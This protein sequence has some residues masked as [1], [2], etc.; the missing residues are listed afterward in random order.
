MR[1]D[2]VDMIFALTSYAMF[3]MLMPGRSTSEL[4]DLVRAACH[5]A[6]DAVAVAAD[7]KIRTS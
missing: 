6:L 1:Q 7:R 5:R 2:A 4:R 3:A